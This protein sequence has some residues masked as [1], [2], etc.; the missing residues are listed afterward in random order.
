MNWTKSIKKGTFFL[1][2]NVTE[3]VNTDKKSPL[4]SKWYNF[5]IVF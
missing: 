2:S 3:T 1:K 5:M 4:T